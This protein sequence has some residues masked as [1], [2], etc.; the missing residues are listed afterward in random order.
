[1]LCGAKYPIGSAKYNGEGS[2]DQQVKKQSSI[3]G[4]HLTIGKN[5]TLWE[6]RGMR[7]VSILERAD[8]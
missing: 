6:N 1:M 4:H 3:K 5:V 7:N 2:L 8:A